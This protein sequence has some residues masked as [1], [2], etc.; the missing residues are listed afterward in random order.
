MVRDENARTACA[1]E[2]EK[3]NGKEGSAPSQGPRRIINNKKKKAG[4]RRKGTSKSHNDAVLTRAIFQKSRS[5]KFNYKRNR[6]R[7]NIWKSICQVDECA[8][9][10]WF[11]SPRRPESRRSWWPVSRGNSIHL[12]ATPA[13]LCSTTHVQFNN[14]HV[15]V[16]CGRRTLMRLVFSL[17]FLLP[18]GTRKSVHENWR[19]NGVSW[20]EAMMTQFWAGTKRKDDF[21]MESGE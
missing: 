17:R 12:S 5:S 20:N 16:P 6:L 7:I 21:R 2:R 15:F 10:L 1:S 19:K 8:S 9:W 13:A 3:N 4:E 14:R 11:L 18:R